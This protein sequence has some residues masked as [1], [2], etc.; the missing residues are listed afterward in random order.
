MTEQVKYTH[1]KKEKKNPIYYK[2]AGEKKTKCIRRRYIEKNTGTGCSERGQVHQAHRGE[3]TARGRCPIA[4]GVV[5]LYITSLPTYN[6]TCGMYTVVISISQETTT[7]ATNGKKI[8]QGSILVCAAAG[9]RLLFFLRHFTT[10]KKNKNTGPDV[11]RNCF[12]SVLE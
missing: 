10:Q 2:R 12:V 8:K 11:Y 6:I 7:G 9:R 4:G 3:S 1:K 5:A